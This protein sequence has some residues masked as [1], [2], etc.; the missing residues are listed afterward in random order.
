MAQ[1]RNTIWVAPSVN[2]AILPRSG[3]L[4]TPDINGH[5]TA[6]ASGQ[7]A[8]D[9]IAS[10]AV[11]FFSPYI[12]KLL[13][14]NFNVTTDQAIPLFIPG[15]ASV[16]L[17]RISVLNASHTLATAAGGIYPT[18]AKGGTAIVAATQAFTAVTTG[19]LALDLTLVSANIVY[20]AS[21][22]AVVG[23]VYSIYLSLT[24]AEGAA[25]TADCYVYGDIYE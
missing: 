18:T 24:T 21:A 5:I 2:Q 1:V 3:V 10:G 22:W 23:G 13:G 15:G 6:P 19:A 9:L 17:T 14:A 8:A 12:G 25:A 11:P 4:Y 20:P 7:D 16:R